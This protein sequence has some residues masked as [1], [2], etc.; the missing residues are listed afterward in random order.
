MK[1]YVRLDTSRSIKAHRIGGAKCFG[2]VH[3][4]AYRSGRRAQIYSAYIILQRIHNAQ[5]AFDDHLARTRIN[6]GLRE[7]ISQAA[8]SCGII[9]APCGKSIRPRDGPFYTRAID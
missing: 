1:F 3:F 8:R 5:A 7:A 6:D 2:R 9:R 4:T